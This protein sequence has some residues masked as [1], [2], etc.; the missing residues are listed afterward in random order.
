MFNENNLITSGFLFY[1]QMIYYFRPLRNAV[2]NIAGE[3]Q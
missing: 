1:I 2:V 3:F